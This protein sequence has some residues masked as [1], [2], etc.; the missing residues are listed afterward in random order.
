MVY[1]YFS[2]YFVSPVY[3]WSVIEKY[4]L[5][6]KSFRMIFLV[7]SLRNDRSSSFSKCIN[8]FHMT[9]SSLWI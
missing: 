3:I 2:Q 1:N 5:I 9:G 8:I 6:A 4:Y 7:C